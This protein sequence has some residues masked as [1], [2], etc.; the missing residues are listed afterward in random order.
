[1][2]TSGLYIVADKKKDFDINYFED[3]KSGKRFLSR[4]I[5]W[6]QTNNNA[7][8]IIASMISS[9]QEEKVRFYY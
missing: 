4:E 9:A 7:S 2:H 5:E 1:M 8:N 3:V 6:L